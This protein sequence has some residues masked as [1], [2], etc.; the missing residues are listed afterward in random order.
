MS[1]DDLVQA[2]AQTVAFEALQV[3]DTGLQVRLMG[4]LPQARMQD[5][6]TLIGGL[7]GAAKEASWKVDVSKVYV[8]PPTGTKVVYAWRLIF[9][10]TT[11]Q[12]IPF[13]DTIVP[14][15][16]NI[17]QRPRSGTGGE[18][19]VEVALP[20]AGAYRNAPNQR[21]KGA[22]VFG[23]AVVGKAFRQGM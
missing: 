1:A 8:L 16:R 23:Q 17:R 11:D 5:M 22:A 7:L 4:R 13:R 12:P 18:P 9:E 21:G 6:L 3:N 15:V 14:I 2:L 19:L 10:S 20:G